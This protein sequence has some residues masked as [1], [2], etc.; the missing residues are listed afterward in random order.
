MQL[1]K[2]IIIWSSVLLST[3]TFGQYTPKDSATIHQIGDE[4]LHN[5]QAYK[6]LNTLC[7][8]IGHRLS[9]S[10]ASL[11]AVHWAKNLLE[12]SGADTVYL[13][14]VMVPVWERGKES[15]RINLKGSYKN[16][17]ILSLGN[18]EGT[19]G[20]DVQAEII[21][22][23]TIE[24]LKAAPANLIKGK[25]VFLNAVFPK[26]VYTTF[27]GYGLIASNRRN[28][29]NIS[30]AK[31]AVGFLLRS[32]STS[33]HDIPHTGMSHYAD[34]VAKIPALAIGTLTA[35]ELNNA[36]KSRKISA[37]INSNC[38]MKGMKLSYNVIGELKGSQNPNKYLVAGAHLDSWDVGE[39]AHD[40]GAGCMQVVE[41]LRTWKAV[42]YQPQNTLRVVLF[43][44]EENGNKGGIAY[45]DSVGNKKE[46]HVFAFESDAGGFTPRGI[47]MMVPQKYRNQAQSW[48]PLLQPFGINDVSQEGCG[49]DIGPL[50]KHNTKV[51]ELHP[52]SQRY[53]DFHHNNHDVFE[54]V[55][56]RELHLGAG[57]IASFLYLVDQYWD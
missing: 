10:E 39:G 44:N 12:Q 4:I 52:D 46:Q 23:Q 35:D 16:I 7:K 26:H 37:I 25:I 20:K 21:A 32:I 50:R 5:A 33:K 57:A 1:I 30:S 22:F 45:A 49:V 3:Q 9:G 27:E 2:N 55:N 53:F 38:S 17:D 36:L 24:E 51:G 18:T 14:P 19:N 40:D 29:V 34:S 8:T 11:K 48:L 47:G 54:Q 31:G 42:K 13:Q 43:M 28:G 41:V 56:E 15:V 6:S